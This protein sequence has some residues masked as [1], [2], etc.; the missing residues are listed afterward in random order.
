MLK[1][2]KLL[3]IFFLFTLS[4]LPAIPGFSPIIADTPG[5]WVYYEDKTFIRH[6]YIGIL[7]FDNK[8]YQVVYYAP[9]EKKNA[10]PLTL[11]LYF[12]L[13]ETLPYIK[14]TGETMETM[15]T[16]E[17]S[18]IINYLHD[19]FF[20]LQK[21]RVEGGKVLPQLASSPSSSSNSYWQYKGSVTSNIALF[22]GEI[23]VS[24]NAFIPLFNIESIEDDIGRVKFCLVSMGRITSNL[25]KS[26]TNFPNFIDTLNSNSSN[27]KK[28]KWRESKKSGA[29]EYSYLNQ[30]VTLTTEWV[31]FMEN[32][33][34]LSNVANLTLSQGK[35]KEPLPFI[36]QA[37]YAADGQYL[38]YPSLKVRQEGEKYI[39]E[40]SIYDGGINSFITSIKVLECKALTKEADIPNLYYFSLSVLSSI[41]SENKRY[42]TKILSSYQVD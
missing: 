10:P 28:V 29:L 31:A 25:D 4:F 23:S 39:I 41:Y 35:V 12:T 17:D 24:F 38:C 15:H 5:E 19:L 26:F 1:S 14:Y 21:V 34:F 30:R 27:K 8:T 13:D 36:R 22:G 32:T 18:T 40:T 7:T 3:P 2:A 42:F 33:Y 37:L 20:Y 6:S 9:Q 16:K 11:T